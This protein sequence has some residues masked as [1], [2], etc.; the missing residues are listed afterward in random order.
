[1][2]VVS[3]FVGQFLLPQDIYVPKMRLITQFSE[4]N[5]LNGT[6]LGGASTFATHTNWALG[7]NM[8]LT[9]CATLHHCKK[10]PFF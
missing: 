8:T 10:G 4:T 1:M 9:L 3:V 5:K 6:E 2:T 7:M